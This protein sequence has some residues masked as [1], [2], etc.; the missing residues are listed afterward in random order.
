MNPYTMTS[1]HGSINRVPRLSKAQLIGIVSIATDA[2]ISID[3]EE[4]ITFFNEGAERLFGYTAGEVQDQPVSLLFPECRDSENWRKLLAFVHASRGPLRFAERLR[5]VGH[6]KGGGTFPAEAVLSRIEFEGEWIVTLVLWDLTLLLEAERREQQLMVEQSARIAAEAAAVRMSALTDVGRVLLSSLDHDSTLREL[7]PILVPALADQVIIR[8]VDG[9]GWGRIVVPA[10][11]LPGRTFADLLQA[12]YPM[13]DEL[14]G[15]VHHVLRTGESLHYSEISDGGIATAAEDS[16]YLRVLQELGVTSFILAPLTARGHLLGSIGLF[17]TESGRSYDEMDLA[18]AEDLAARIALALD[19]ARLYRDAEQEIAERRRAEAA[20]HESEMRFRVMADNA[21]VLIWMSDPDGNAYFFNKPWLDFTGRTKEEESR[22]GWL[23]G[24]HQEERQRYLT[25]YLR[26]YE[27]RSPIIMEYRLRRWDGE[28]RWILDHG[29]PRMTPDGEFAGYVGS[30]IDITDQINQR[31]ALVETASQLEELTAEL[32][33]TIEELEVRREEADLARAA[34]DEANRAKSRFLAV[35]SHELRTPLNAILGYGDLL[36]AEVA[37]PISS[38]QRQHLYRIRQS[39]LH[40]LD[41]INKLLSFSRIE[42]GKEELSLERVDLAALARD[43]VA[44][45][46]PQAEKQGLE[47]LIGIPESTV[48]A[49]TDAGKI[50]QILLNL[51]SNAVK[52][53]ERGEVEFRML[54]EQETISF[55]VRDTGAGVPLNEQERIFEPFTQT[56]ETRTRRKGGTGLGLSVSRELARLLG[57]EI[58]IESVLD[59]GSTFTV[60]LP[61]AARIGSISLGR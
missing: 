60:L 6:R 45:V 10:P 46:A 34:A 44:L 38:G 58:S 41:L 49:E 13:D 32:E 37:G 33:Q 29:E 9:E 40:L 53:T 36:D 22:Q 21:P 57:G 15:G 56:D 35:M 55:A 16:A 48:E 27:T 3:N 18:F 28:Y 42:A 14:S 19:N 24:V 4:R 8:L 25:V 43:A 47:L 26:A 20:Q 5:F 61:I 23:E 52:F 31:E 54:V 1:G 17:M 50:R 7:V 30:C 59:Q 39:A 12:R 11:D 2:I 51:L